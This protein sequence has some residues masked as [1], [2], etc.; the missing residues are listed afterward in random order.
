MI[1]IWIFF[2]LLLT[3][4]SMVQNISR[5]NKIVKHSTPLIFS[6]LKKQQLKNVLEPLRCQMAAKQVKQSNKQDI[7][8]ITVG[9]LDMKS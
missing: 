5:K 3:N 8:K 1:Y 7:D 4:P 9:Q 6:T 2:S